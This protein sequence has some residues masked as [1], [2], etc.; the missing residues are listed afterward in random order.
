M[1]M[2]VPKGCQSNWLGCEVEGVKTEEQSRKLKQ[3]LNLGFD[4]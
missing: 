2:L 4:F 3:Y 1:A